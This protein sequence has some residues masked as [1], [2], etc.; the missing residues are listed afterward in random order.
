MNTVSFF[1]WLIWSLSNATDVKVTLPVIQLHCSWHCFD[2]DIDRLGRGTSYRKSKLP[3]QPIDL[4]AYEASPFCKLAREV[5]DSSC[6]LHMLLQHK[7]GMVQPSSMVM[8]LVLLMLHVLSTVPAQVCFICST[9]MNGSFCMCLPESSHVQTQCASDISFPRIPEKVKFLMPD[10][11]FC[12]LVHRWQRSWTT[13][14]SQ[15]SA[16]WGHHMPWVLACLDVAGICW[17]R[18]TPCV[19]HSCTQQPKKA[20]AN[21]QMGCLPGAIHWG[22]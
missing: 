9:L 3:K 18:D 8:R 17:A 2:V 22:K 15:Q 21:R 4:W 10:C 11:W 13:V 6:N 16:L 5:T 19:S 12:N 1:F 14:T 20:G 7:I